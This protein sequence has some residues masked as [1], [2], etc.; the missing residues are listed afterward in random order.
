MQYF[1][2]F[3]YRR[4][5][6]RTLCSTFSVFGNSIYFLSHAHIYARIDFVS[7]VFMLHVNEPIN[8]DFVYFAR[9]TLSHF[10]LEFFFNEI[11]FICQES[12]KKQFYFSTLTGMNF[13]GSKWLKPVKQRSCPTFSVCFLAIEKH[14]TTVFVDYFSLDCRFVRFCFGWTVRTHADKDS[15]RR[16]QISN[17]TVCCTLERI[18]C[19]R[20]HTCKNNDCTV[21]THIQWHA[22]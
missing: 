21:H 17:G 18:W 2:L 6:F 9:F 3:R 22:R 8:E 15:K 19:D 14:S 12:H 13:I 10:F 16:L 11:L 20:T 5:Q 1:F 7:L 4:E